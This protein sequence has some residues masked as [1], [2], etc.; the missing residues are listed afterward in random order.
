MKRR[1]KDSQHCPFCKRRVIFDNFWDINRCNW[2]GAQETSKGWEKRD[3]KAKTLLSK[4]AKQQ[5]KLFL[6]EDEV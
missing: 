1:S 4:C 2:C 6:A 5:L 3:V